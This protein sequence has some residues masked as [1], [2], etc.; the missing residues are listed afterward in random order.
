MH[1]VYQLVGN[2]NTEDVKQGM[3][4]TFINVNEMYRES[5]KRE[6]QNPMSGSTATVALFHNQNLY[7]GIFISPRIT[8]R[9][10]L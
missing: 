2:I 8:L 7:L 6:L 4:D 3:H 10:L 1:L 5:L 9:F